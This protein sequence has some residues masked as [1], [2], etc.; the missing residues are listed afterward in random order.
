MKALSRKWIRVRIRC[1]LSVFLLFFGVAL[2]RAYDLQIVNGKRLKSLGE[3]QAQGELSLLPVRGDI[4]SRNQ[5]PLALTIDVDSVYAHPQK[6]GHKKELA[7]EVAPVLGLGSRALLKQLEA[8]NRFV[9]LKRHVTPHEKKRLLNLDLSAVHFTKENKRFYPNREIAAHVVGFAGLDCQGLEGIELHYDAALAGT[10]GFPAGQRDGRGRLIPLSGVEWLRSTKGHSLI[11]TIDEAIQYHVEEGLR[12]TV[13]AWKAKGGQAIVMVPRTGEVLA[14][15]AYPTFNPNEFGKYDPS[16]MRNRAITDCFEPGSTFKAFVAAAALEEGVATPGDLI[17]CENGSYQYGGKVIRDDVH[18]YG[19]LTFK[20]VIQYSSNIGASKI[21]QTLGKDSLYKY[22]R[23]F[24]FG[25][26]TGIDFPGEA[27]GLVRLPYGWS[28][29]DG[30]A[31]CFGQG[32]LVS[33]IQLA[34]AFSAIA[35]GGLLMKPHLVKRI[36]ND[37]GAV[38]REFQ[39]EV[40][41]QVLSKSTAATVTSILQ[42]VTQEGGTGVE[43]RLSGFS[44]AGKTGTAQ[45]VDPFTGRY[46]SKHSVASFVGFLPAENPQLTILAI[47]DEPRGISYGGVVAAP[48]FRQIASQCVHSLGISPEARLKAELPKAESVQVASRPSAR[49]RAVPSQTDGADRMP[50]LSG[51]SIR[52]V[53]KEIQDLNL[54]L[55][56]SGSGRVRGQ[57][58]LPGTPLDE[59]DRCSVELS[60]SSF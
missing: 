6:I 20:Q 27:Q 1:T 7:R 19:W 34:A 44:V 56:I 23:K 36:V 4:Y 60:A 29:I 30:A 55:H 31:I 17:F 52:Q 45:K 49:E 32:V 59:G 8:G 26:R 13:M 51:L 24:G 41:R 39:P 14:L 50:D 38:I 46:S 15:A 42:E 28:K 54:N 25:E 53:I 21:G 11:L 2:W 3:R 16:A 43:A 37:D 10:P 35:N 48:L 9:W 22:I 58:P 18:E 33:P 5:E 47:I 12:K 40:R 57:T